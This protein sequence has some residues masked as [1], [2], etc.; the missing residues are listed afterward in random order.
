[1]VKHPSNLFGR[2]VVVAV[3]V[4]GSAPFLYYEHV[5]HG[6]WPKAIEK[7]YLVTA[8]LF[9]VLI[10]AYWQSIRRSWFWKALVPIAL[11]HALIV[12]AIVKAN[13]FAPA[14]DALPGYAYGGL[15][16]LLSAEVYASIRIIDVFESKAHKRHEMT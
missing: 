1:M 3:V 10:H 8:G 9:A 6:T 7:A 5:D 16:T 12:L 11:A 4:L 15:L 13:L 2:Y 14:I